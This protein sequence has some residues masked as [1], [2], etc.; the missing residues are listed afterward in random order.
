MSLS[1]INISLSSLKSGIPRE[2]LNSA[3]G[4]DSLGIILISDLP[5]SY[6]SLRSKVLKSASLL[7]K[8]DSQ[9]LESMESS[10]AFWLVG[11]SRGKEKLTIQK[12][13][14]IIKK[15]DYLKGSYYINCSFFIDPTLEGPPTEERERFANHKAYV[16][17]NKWPDLSSL[18]AR[19]LDE[20]EQNAKALCNLIIQIALNV[21]AVCDKF[22]A[23]ELTDAKFSF[24]GGYCESVV[25]NS[26]TTKA[27]LLHYYPKSVTEVKDE[28]GNIWCGEHL[29]HSV[30]TGLT[31]AMYIDESKIA[32]K[33]FDELQ[34][35]D[36]D[37]LEELVASPDPESGLYIK[38]RQGEVVKVDIPKDCLA[39]QTGSALQEISQERFKAVPHYVKGCNVAGVARNTL[40]VFCQPNLGENVNEKETFSEY[41]ER[42]LSGNH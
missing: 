38:S 35:L 22:I 14:E 15:P 26:Y 25:K 12:G 30:L 42:I 29:D 39:F 11:W 17:L 19:V 13:S 5:S 27:R 41:A 3:F 33:T 34:Q 9:V 37:G 24:P 20:F 28:T 36:V 2:S 23:S 18:R 10:E 40:A 6:R 8:L 4:P 32:E 7:S 16:T 21:A 31:S 1:P